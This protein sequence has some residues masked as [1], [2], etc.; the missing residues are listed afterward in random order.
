MKH[1]TVKNRET[2]HITN[3]KVTVTHYFKH[4]ASVIVL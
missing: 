4:Y 1:N 3:A 2:K